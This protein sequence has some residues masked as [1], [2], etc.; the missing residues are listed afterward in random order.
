MTNEEITKYS[1]YPS[2]ALADK[3]KAQEYADFIY[4]LE[5]KKDED[6]DLLFAEFYKFMDSLT[7][8]HLNHLNN[9]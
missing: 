7:V 6:L 1:V 8:P 5:N 4:F 3:V 9:K 2:Q